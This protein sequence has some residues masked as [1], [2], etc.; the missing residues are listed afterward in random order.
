M[1]EKPNDEW[2]KNY[3]RQLEETF[4]QEEVLIRKMRVDLL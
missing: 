3:K 2:W 1:T 4:K